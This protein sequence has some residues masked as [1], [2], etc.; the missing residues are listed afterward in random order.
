MTHDKNSI[1]LDTWILA[2]ASSANIVKSG[3]A[4]AWSDVRLEGLSIFERDM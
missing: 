3:A 4:S 1:T 2:L